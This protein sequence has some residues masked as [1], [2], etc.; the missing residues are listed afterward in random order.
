MQSQQHK[1]KGR[2]SDHPPLKVALVAVL[3]SIWLVGKG[4]VLTAQLLD[5]LVEEADFSQPQLAQ[6]RA[7]RN[8]DS[9]P[10]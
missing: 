7:T 6:L 1:T 5:E 2:S 9:I 4:G 10:Q 3:V 8:M